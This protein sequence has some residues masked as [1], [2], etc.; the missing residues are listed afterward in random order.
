MDTCPKCQFAIEPGAVECPACGV[1]LAKLRSAPPPPRPA[2]SIQPDVPYPAPVPQP[3]P[4]MAGPEE[5]PPL[6]P[7]SPPRPA[8]T[9]AKPVDRYALPVLRLTPKPARPEGQAAQAPA[10]ASAPVPASS[11]P[12]PSSIPG[13]PMPA[14]PYAPP[15]AP[16]ASPAGVPAP[17]PP[18]DVITPATVAALMASRP[19][20]R[21]LVALGFGMS[22]LSFA[23]GALLFTSNKLPGE[24]QVLALVFFLDAAVGIAVILPLNRSVRALDD[25]AQYKMSTVVETYAVEQVHFWRRTGVMYLA[26]LAVLLAG[27]VMGTMG[28]AF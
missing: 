13:R 3:A 5:P 16:N 9:P 8:T 21:V 6:P 12:A 15:L 24:V 19:W 27:I 25:A 28:N 20:I 17:Y 26:L 10:A 4:R 2:A 7:P 22:L 1:I 11:I 18:A 14:N 23:A